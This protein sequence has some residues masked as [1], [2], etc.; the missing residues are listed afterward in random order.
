MNEKSIPHITVDGPG[1]SGKGTISLLLARELGWHFLDSGALYRA[2]AVAVQQM[3]VSIEDEAGLATLAKD[4]P[5]AFH[6]FQVSLSG[7]DITHD[8]RSEQCGAAASKLAVFPAVREALLSRQRAFLQPPGLIADGRDMGTVVFPE[9]PLKLY[10]EA[11]LDERAKRRYLQL[12]ER[13]QNVTLDKILQEIAARDARDKNRA[14]A[15]LSPAKEAIIVDTT[16]MAI[17]EVF[18]KVMKIVRKTGL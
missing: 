2:L 7:Q 17:P 1:G 5:V 10:L 9:A 18:E 15:P 3:K 13:G 11:S 14:T 8:L 4:L 12:K 6:E 16:N